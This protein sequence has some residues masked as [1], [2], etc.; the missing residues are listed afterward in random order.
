MKLTLEA[1][2]SHLRQ[3]K[4]APAY[5]VS[6]DEDL[7]V[8]EAADAIRAAARAAGYGEREVHFPE[9][10][11]D[12]ADI[13]ASAGSMSLFGDRRVL[14]IRFSGKAGKEG[15]AALA[16]LIETAGDDTLLLVITPRL[17]AAVQATAWVKAIEARGAW[18]PVWEVGPRQ[19]ETWLAARCKRAGLEPTADALALLA[20]RVEGNLLAAQQEIEKLR[21]LVP[22]GRLDAAAVMG[23]VVHSA[24]YDVFALGEA[25]VTGDAVRAARVVAGLRGEGVEPTLV[26]WSLVRE[27]RNMWSLRRGDDPARRPGPRLPPAQLAALERA[28]PRAARL[29]FARLA[30]RALRADR[31]IKG[32]LAGDP[33]DEMLL[34]CAEFCGTRLRGT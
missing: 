21:L 8:G 3:G 7:L 2:G 32:R 10:V 4:P 17:E 11:A 33:W 29:P 31:M 24:R 9:R 20:A 15:G 23:A 16:R 6:G 5:L 13:A 18:L 28:R 25:V 14:E 12:W 26:L 27:L 34:L 30:S 19:L 22:A 1:L